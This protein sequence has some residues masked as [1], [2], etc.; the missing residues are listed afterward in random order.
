LDMRYVETKKEFTAVKSPALDTGRGVG[1][2]N[3]K[4]FAES[5]MH[6]P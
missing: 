3:A 1:R 2:R 4:T 6:V 5:V